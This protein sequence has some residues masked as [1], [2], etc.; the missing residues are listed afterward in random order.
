MNQEITNVNNVTPVTNNVQTTQDIQSQ[1]T[2]VV[3]TP[4]VQ[5]VAPEMSAPV[6]NNQAVATEDIPAPVEI[7][8]PLDTEK[9]F[10]LNE[11]PVHID[12]DQENLDRMAKQ[13]ENTMKQ[14]SQ[15]GT[16]QTQELPKEQ[17]GSIQF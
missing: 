17:T 13:L 10:V 15:Q 7:K 16:E 5:P 3:E 8:E 1:T 12:I 6:V 2:P 9:V 11:D 4:T 14:T